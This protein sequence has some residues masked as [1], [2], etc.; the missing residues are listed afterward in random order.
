[1]DPIVEQVK[2]LAEGTDEAGRRNL[3]LALRDLSYSLETPKD[4]INRILSYVSITF[5]P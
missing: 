5:S 4:T 3:A 2:R 1:M